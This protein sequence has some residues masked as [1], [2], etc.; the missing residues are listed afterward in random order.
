MEI[1]KIELYRDFVR[2][3]IGN[4]TIAKIQ[5]KY[6]ISRQAVYQIANQV[7]TGKTKEYQSAVRDAKWKYIYSPTYEVVKDLA[8][9]GEQRLFSSML[10]SM[11]KDGFSIS[12]VAKCLGRG[13]TSDR[14]IIYNYLYK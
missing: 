13:E 2:V 10:R 9:I 7:A 3:R 11:V 12:Q 14:K 8:T 6:K 1:N 5:K 4:T